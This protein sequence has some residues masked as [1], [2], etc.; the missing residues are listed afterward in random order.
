MTKR[1]QIIAVANQKGGVGKTTTV[2]NLAAALA[3]QRRTVLVVDLD[4]Q[5][6]A[7]G[8]LGLEK[9]AGVSIYPVLMGEAEIADVI[10][11]T[12]Y[13]NLNVI[14]SE[15]DLAGAEIEIARRDDHLTVICDAL[16]PVRE[17]GVFDYILLDCP[18]SLGIVMT[19]SLAAVDGVLV[20]MQA[21]FLAMEGLGLI[22]NLLEQLRDGANPSLRLNGILLTMVDNRTKNAKEISSA[23]RE[24]VG[25][26]IRVFEAEIP[27][28]VRVAESSITGQ[29][30][31]AYDKG[32]KAALAYEALTKEVMELEERDKDRS[33]SDWIR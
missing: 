27:R 3:R 5:A 4:P 11:P 26:N 29:S 9:T 28:S 12:A 14:P 15:V 21:E 20:P 1:T 25:Q 31:L 24:T 13:D 2:V 23:L 17:S 7:T 6:N 22:T 30:I 16:A 10:Q 32:G 19:A 8:G 33:R 18:P